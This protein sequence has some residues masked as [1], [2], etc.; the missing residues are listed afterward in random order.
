MVLKLVP[1]SYKQAIQAVQVSP[2]SL[3]YGQVNQQEECTLVRIK[4]KTKDL[5]YI[6][7]DWLIGNLNALNTKLDMISVVTD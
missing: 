3:I 4:A 6:F 2:N 1:L 7:F 5:K